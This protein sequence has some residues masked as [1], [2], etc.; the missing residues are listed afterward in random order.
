MY[1]KVTFSE[2]KTTAKASSTMVGSQHE[3][4]KEG[5]I[6]DQEPNNSD[7]PFKTSLSTLYIA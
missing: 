1:P 6:A 5:R 2:S 4:Q 3:M 7:P